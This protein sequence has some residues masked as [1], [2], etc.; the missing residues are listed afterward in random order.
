M[1]KM[2]NF[3]P[4]LITFLVLSISVLFISCEKV[5]PIETPE[6]NVVTN[7]TEYPIMGITWV[8]TDGR[9][10]IENMD[11][12][13]K[14]YYDH[15]GQNQNLSVLNPFDGAQVPFDTLIQDVTTWNFGNSNFTLNGLS[16]YGLAGT[17]TSINVNGLENG[18]SRT[19]TVL[20]LTDNKLTVQVGE[21]YAS[22]GTNN[23]HYFSTLTFVPAGFTCSSCQPDALY[24]YTYGGT[25]SITNTTSSII[26]TK[27]VVTKFYDG[28]ANNYPNDTLDFFSGTQYKINNGTSMNYTLSGIIGNNMSELTLYGFYTIGGDFSGM[29][30]DN[31]VVNGEINSALFTDIF[32][33]NNDKLVW[34]VRIQ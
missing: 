25:I 19:M 20:E 13:D 23:Y 28:F 34:M 9:I 4:K 24:G 30:P 12:N 17:T 18:S 16:S 1:F 14:S 33:T 5:E 8:L 32:N 6:N 15:F 29:V 2:K 3:I 22:D 11:N 26:G 7:Q 21:G 10:Y 27:W 31:F